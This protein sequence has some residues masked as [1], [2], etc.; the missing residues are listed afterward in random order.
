MINRNKKKISNKQI[1]QKKIKK[2]KKEKNVQRQFNK[3]RSEY[4]RLILTKT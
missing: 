3:L 1:K 4:Q 2:R